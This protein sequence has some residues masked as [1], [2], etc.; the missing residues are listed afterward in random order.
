VLSCKPLDSFPF[1]RSRDVEE[2]REALASVYV[3]PVLTPARGAE[4]FDARINVCPLKSFGVAY[5]SFGTEVSFDFPASGYFSQ[6][7]PL[8]G[9]GEMLCGGAAVTLT[10]GASALVPAGLSHQANYSADYEHLVL[11]ISAKALTGKIDALDRG[12]RQHAVAG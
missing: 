3:R 1:V 12:R 2:A 5:G 7:F 4:G 8:R 11:R 6:I 10:P 9:K